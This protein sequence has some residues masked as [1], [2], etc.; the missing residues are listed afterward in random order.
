MLLGF[1]TTNGKIISKLSDRH[2]MSYF[3]GF[4]QMTGT[5][6][7]LCHF[8]GSGE[9]AVDW[10]AGTLVSAGSLSTLFLISSKVPG[11][12]AKAKVWDVKAGPKSAG[13]GTLSSQ[14]TSSR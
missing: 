6:R 1:S 9:K 12:T 8:P 5:A 4:P 3:P 10:H 14:L 7:W 13:A 11:M 2:M